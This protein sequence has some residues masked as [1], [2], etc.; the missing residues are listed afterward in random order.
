MKSNLIDRAR[1]PDE[2][3]ISLHEHDGSYFIRVDG[4]P[5]MSTRQHSSEERLAELRARFA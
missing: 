1:T 4:V 3:T 5:L 2:K